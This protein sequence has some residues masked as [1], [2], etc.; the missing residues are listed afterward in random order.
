MNNKI[1]YSLNKK[2]LYHRNVNYWKSLKN[3]HSGKPGWIIGNGPSLKLSDLNRLTNHICIA[4]NKIYLAFNEIRWR[5]KYYTIVDREIWANINEEAV[6]HF[7]QIHLPTS[8][9]I[10]L[11]SK[12]TALRYFTELS[13]KDDY[14]KFSTNA[15]KGFYAGHS[16]TF[17]NL[18][19]ACY[20]GLNPIY[21]IGCD[22]SYKTLK[23]NY[24]D[25]T[26]RNHFDPNYIEKDQMILQAPVDKMDKA[27]NYAENYTRRNGIKIINATRGGNLRAFERADIDLIKL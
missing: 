12:P 18:Q 17:L 19:L 24:V 16:V 3:I 10:K 6:K 2:M 9:N 23:N 21:L 4:S 5:P 26:A 13:V 27:F 25:S 20:L 1:K 22:H 11:K 8:L 15:P 14:Q 7:Q